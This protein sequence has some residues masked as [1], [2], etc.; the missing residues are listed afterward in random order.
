M[1]NYIIFVD[2]ETLMESEIDELLEG[3]E[4]DIEDERI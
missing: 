2:E 3:E 4:F 1:N